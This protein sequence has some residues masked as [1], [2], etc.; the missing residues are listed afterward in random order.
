M[1]NM[2]AKLKNPF[3]NMLYWVKGEIA[4]IKSMT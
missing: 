4:D 1:Q 3:N 2:D